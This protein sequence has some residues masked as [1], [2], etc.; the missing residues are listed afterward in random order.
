MPYIHKESMFDIEQVRSHM[1]VKYIEIQYECL[2]NLIFF[3][4]HACWQPY[5]ENRMNEHE[6]IRN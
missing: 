5:V 4:W 1:N 6:W 3:C 2:I